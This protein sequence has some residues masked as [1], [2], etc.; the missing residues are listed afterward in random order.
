M[1][2][3]VRNLAVLPLSIALVFS[4]GACGKKQDSNV[5]VAGDKKLSA[6]DIDRDPL[7]LLP[8][9]MVVLAQ[10][11][12]A[13]FLASQTGPAA[14]RI[15]QN[16][17]P[18]TPE[19]GFVPSRDL[20]T[21]VAGVYSMS[22]ADVAAIVQGTYDVDAIKRAADRGAI[23]ALGKPL[24]RVD[25]ANNDLYLSGDVGFVLLTPHTLLVGN[26]AGMRRALD[27]IRDGRVKR[28]IPDWMVQLLATPNAQVVVAAD[29]AGQSVSA[30]VSQ[31]VP[32]L[33]GLRTARLIGNFQPPGINFAGT[34]TY[35]DGTGA[36]AGEAQMKNVAQMAGWLNLLGMFGVS[37]PI[38]QMDT[39]VTGPDLQF[40]LALDGPAL[41]ALLSQLA[42]MTQLV[43]PAP[44]AAR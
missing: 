37:S 43:A 30:A 17:V 31:Q 19:M 15:S 3:W 22:G 38:K 11:D 33:Q 12:A 20:K 32:F 16:L 6:E 10:A 2:A 35:P 26:P 24:S 7:A 36:A 8:G 21:I 25:Y 4:A 40:L 23:S 1:N 41:A 28:E 34:F 39:R 13:A 27:R 18:L 14:I 5:T 29:L 9:G 44:P 42:S